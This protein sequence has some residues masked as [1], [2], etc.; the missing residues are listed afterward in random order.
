MLTLKDL[1][2]AQ[3]L[4]S[5]AMSAVSGGHGYGYGRYGHIHG[6]N[7]NNKGVIVGGDLS[8]VFVGGDNSGTIQSVGGISLD[9]DKNKVMIKF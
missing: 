3:E 9:G 2:Q 6:N 7:N 1:P 4:D 8:G 5:R